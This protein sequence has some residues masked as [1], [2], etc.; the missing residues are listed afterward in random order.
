MIFLRRYRKYTSFTHHD[1]CK[2]HSLKDTEINC[3]RYFQIQLKPGSN[4]KS[5]HTINI[6]TPHFMITIFRLMYTPGCFIS[7]TFL[8]SIKTEVYFIIRPTPDCEFQITTT[9]KDEKRDTIVKIETQ[10]LS[11]LTNLLKMYF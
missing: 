11:D 8:N 2:E 4:K 9:K 6:Y 7:M 10:R 1:Q 5:K 3:L